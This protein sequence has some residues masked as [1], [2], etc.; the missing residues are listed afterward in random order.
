VAGLATLIGTR[1]RE[2]WVVAATTLAVAAVF[3]PLRRRIQVWIDRRFNRSRFDAQK[4]MDGFA[5]SLRDE[6]QL[7]AVVEG[8]VG[9]VE[10]TMQPAALGV[11]VRE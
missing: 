11:W 1:F 7:Q 2:P 3:N 6:V 8:W 4:V 5:G 9:V 10:E